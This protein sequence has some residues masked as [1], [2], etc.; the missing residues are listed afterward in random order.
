MSWLSFP[1]HVW[2]LT[3]HWSILVYCGALCSFKVGTSLTTSPPSGST[4]TAG[5]FSLT[6]ESSIWRP[7]IHLLRGPASVLATNIW[8]PFWNHLSSSPR[9][10]NHLSLSCSGS[11]FLFFLKIPALIISLRTT[12]L[13]CLKYTKSLK[14]YLECLST[15][16]CST[17]KHEKSINFLQKQGT[18]N[19]FL[20]E[21]NI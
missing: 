6:P 5:I 9:T 21:G 15:S 16:N 7:H 18:Q 14:C 3:G 8:L 10:L 20:C 19:S 11:L 12:Q 4:L 13:N 1:P 2:T 17:L